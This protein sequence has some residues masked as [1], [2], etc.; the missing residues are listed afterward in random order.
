M[1]VLC[2]HLRYTCTILVPNENKFLHECT[3]NRNLYYYRSRA[4]LLS[5]SHIAVHYK[6]LLITLQAQNLVRVKDPNSGQTVLIKEQ[7]FLDQSGI[8]WGEII[9]R[10]RFTSVYRVLP[11]LY[12]IHIKIETYEYTL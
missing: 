11:L 3:P 12:S 7:R 8:A 2:E 4:S 6:C 5:N 1:Y 9:L 10:V